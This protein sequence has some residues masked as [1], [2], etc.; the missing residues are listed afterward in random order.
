VQRLLGVFPFLFGN[1]FICG[2]LLVGEV[3]SFG[4]GLFYRTAPIG[5][6]VG[7]SVGVF[8]FLASGLH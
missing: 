7:S 3:T 1:P 5:F 4:E 8:F 2:T 6:L